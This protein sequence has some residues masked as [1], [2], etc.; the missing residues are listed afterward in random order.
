M[1]QL[2]E[3]IETGTNPRNAGADSHPV[4]L[5]TDMGEGLAV[6][7]ITPITTQ[8]ELLDCYWQERLTRT[9]HLVDF[10]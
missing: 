8:L 2:I 1:A 4:Q 5:A 7:A 3:P 10:A 9:D 6:Q